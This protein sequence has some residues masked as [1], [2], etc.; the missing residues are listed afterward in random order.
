MTNSIGKWRQDRAVRRI[1]PGDGR[2]LKP[3]RWWQL[4]GRSLFYLRLKTGDGGE[5]VY[6]VDVRHAGNSTT[7]EVEANLFLNGRL[8]LRS[9]TPAAFPVQGGTIEVQTSAFG[10]KRAHYVAVDGTERQLAPDSH[11]AEGRREHFDRA[12][13]G[14]SSLVGTITLVVLVL[15]LAILVP[16]LITTFTQIPP[17]ADSIGTFTSPI[18][19]SG[20]TNAAVT[21]VTGIA[22][23]E[24]ALRLRHNWLLDGGA[25]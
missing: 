19:L 24:R 14:L 11:S 23:T 10:L 6:A 5:A 15:G 1:K 21:V 25:G 17:I 13:P 4:L 22:S 20:W 2:P 16:Q 9:K 12:Y 7:G 18:Q 8:F 3:F